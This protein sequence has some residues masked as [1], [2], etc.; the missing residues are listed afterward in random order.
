[1][2]VYRMNSTKI[3]STHITCIKISQLLNMSVIIL[4]LHRN[5]I[6]SIMIKHQNLSCFVLFGFNVAFNH[7][8]VESQRSVIITLAALKSVS[9]LSLLWEH[10]GRVFD[11]RPR[12]YRF[13]PNRHTCVVSLRKTH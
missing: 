4:K 5:S 8:T 11:T 1:M 9:I 10:S 7:F 3:S 12:G 13:E 2:Y 6:H